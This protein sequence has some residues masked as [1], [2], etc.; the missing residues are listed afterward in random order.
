[1]AVPK[2]EWRWFG[3]A[4]HYICADNCLFHLCTLVGE[5]LVSTI[6]E[7]VPESEAR[8]ILAKSRN[9][10]LEGIG[11]ARKRD[12]L[13]KVGFAEIGGRLYETMV[14]LAGKPCDTPKCGCGLPTISGENLDFAGYNSA[15]DAADG[16][17]AM[18]EKWAEK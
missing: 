11:D 17:Y 4:G 15:K 16:H 18:C 3:H 8:E 9:I 7:L 12:W 2:T 14:F 5:Y 10:V 13:R 1:M 6:G